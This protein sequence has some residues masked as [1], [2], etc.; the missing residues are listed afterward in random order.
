[1]PR[2]ERFER[3]DVPR[4]SAARN[5]V[6]VVV[7]LLVFAG[8]YLLVTHLWARVQRE[9]H[10]ED[11]GL[12]DAVAAQSVAD[13]A[14]DGYQRSTD[15][16]TTVLV[17]TA[18]GLDDGSALRSAEVLVA[19]ETTSVAVRLSV[20]TG[21]SIAV[22]DQTYTLADLY[23]VQGASSCVAPLASASG[24]TFD[25]VIVTTADDVWG[26]LSALAGV[27]AVELPTRGADLLDAS[28]TDLS[29]DGLANLASLVSALGVA[30]VAPTDAPTYPSG[31]W[32]EDG[33]WVDD[34]SGVTYLYASQIL[35]A[36]GVL[37]PVQADA[38]AAEAAA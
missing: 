36:A 22:G 38:G 3:S 11:S 13:V 20:P 6:A 30:G 21:V 2:R 26:P 33:S 35:Q 23:A 1:M 34:G 12:A 16:F 10:L 17:L 7:V 27:S 14:A 18:E 9:G 29:A 32:G 8:L 37:V 19:D 24:L 4:P 31:Y 28:L 25:H 5:V 15:T